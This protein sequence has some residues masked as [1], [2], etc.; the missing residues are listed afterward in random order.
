[1]SETRA[2]NME[3][4][5]QRILD[6]ARAIIIDKGIDGLTTR[7]LAEAAGVTAPTLYNLI[8]DK[9]AIIG[10]MIGEGV[11]RV[12]AKLD[13]EACETPLEMAEMIIETA[14]EEVLSN[15]D[16]YRAVSLATD[17][18]TGSYAARGDQAADHAVAGQRS[19]E[20][21]ATACR[22]AI[23]QGYLNGR[24]AADTLGLQMFISYRGPMR[25][26]AHRIIS[27][28]ECRRRQLRGFYMAMATDAT[29]EFRE[30]LLTKIEALETDGAAV[31]A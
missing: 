14:Y 18:V 10:A 4:R 19:V 21:A 6:A 13:F 26:F 16:Y 24:I 30:L 3:K 8:G 31:A 29:P 23:A 22:A 20:M 12:W 9:D 27:V 17:R 1:M 7:G 5:R 2:R 11:E 25:D 28:E 15:Q